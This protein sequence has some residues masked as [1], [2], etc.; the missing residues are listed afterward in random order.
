MPS[1]LLAEPFSNGTLFAATLAH[2]LRQPLSTMLVALDLIRLAKST[3][4]AERAVEV[5]RRQVAQMSRLVEDVVD[6]ARWANGKISVTK[7]R[8]DLRDVMRATAAEVEA[9]S[10]L[11]HQFVVDESRAPLWVD[12][13]RQRMVQVISNLLR[14]AVAFTPAGGQITIGA[15]QV[16]PEVVLRVRDQGR[17]IDAASLPHVFE[18]F[19]QQTPHEGSG[20]GIGLSVVREIVLLHGGSIEA[21]SEGAQRGSE[22]VVRL[23]LAALTVP[24]PNLVPLPQYV[25]AVDVSVLAPHLAQ[26][27]LHL[28]GRPAAAVDRAPL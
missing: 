4:A 26:S 9:T 1:T 17:G 15:H 8:L 28:C 24:R 5:A 16:G 14:N 13:D 10:Q 12:G 2:E 22:F 21:R 19:S 25:A 7:Q 23:P 6:R 11:H 27:M 18:L 20:L 3:A